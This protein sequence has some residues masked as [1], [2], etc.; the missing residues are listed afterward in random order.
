METDP[1]RLSRLRAEAASNAKRSPLFRWMIDNHDLI[2]AVAS[3]IGRL[4][5]EPMRT[6]ATE[7]GIRDGRGS[8]VTCE[9]MWRL[10][11]KVRRAQS[12]LNQSDRKASSAAPPRNRIATE[13]ATPSEKEPRDSRSK[14]VLVASTGRKLAEVPRSEETNRTA[15]DMTPEGSLA[16]A[17]RVMQERADRRVGIFREN[18]SE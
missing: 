9:Q 10:W 2:A 11:Y 15:A 13:R 14:T 5:W 3:G 17:L 12:R 7:A 6:L 1:L 8:E 18:D 4:N 16:R